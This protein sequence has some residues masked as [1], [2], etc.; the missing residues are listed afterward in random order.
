MA[1]RVYICGGKVVVVG[2][3]AQVKTATAQIENAMAKAYAES[4]KDQGRHCLR[5]LCS[6]PSQRAPPFTLHVHVRRTASD[7]VN[8][9]GF[10]AGYDARDSAFDDD[11]W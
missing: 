8:R 4:A 9:A 11:D 2:L 10:A 7:R 3:P 6:Q 5:P 1:S